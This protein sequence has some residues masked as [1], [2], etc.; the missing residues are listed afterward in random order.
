MTATTLLTLRE[1]AELLHVPE[2]TLAYWV[3]KG[4]APRS[5]KIGRR[6]MFRAVD[7]EAFI[8]ER[9]AAAEAS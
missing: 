9:F 5:A 1:A 2:A 6:R 4:T 7:V 3:H 8:S